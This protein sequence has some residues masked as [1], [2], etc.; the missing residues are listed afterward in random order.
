MFLM[1]IISNKTILLR[2]PI[3]CSSPVKQFARLLIK[4]LLGSKVYV[5]E[6]GDP[7]YVLYCNLVAQS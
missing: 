5:V 3:K 6:C 2:N 4:I 1:K 7:F